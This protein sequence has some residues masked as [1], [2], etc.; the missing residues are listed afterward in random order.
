[1]RGQIVDRLADLT[2]ADRET[3]IARLI[4]AGKVAA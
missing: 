4:D 3:V 2:D 1:M